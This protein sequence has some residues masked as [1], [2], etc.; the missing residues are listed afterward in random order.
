MTVAAYLRC[1]GTSYPT[2]EARR[3]ADLI[4]LSVGDQ[5]IVLA[6]SDREDNDPICSQEDRRLRAQ[7]INRFNPKDLRLVAT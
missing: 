5:D 3:A 1:P 7:M 4:G 6:A 2:T